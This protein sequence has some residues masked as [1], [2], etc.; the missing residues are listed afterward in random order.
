MKKNFLWL[1][2]PACVISIAC[3]QPAAAAPVTYTYTGTVDHGADDF[4]L[5]GVGGAS[6]SG[7]AFTAVFTRDDALA[8]DGIVVGAFSSSITEF[9]GLGAVTGVITIN[10]VAYNVAPG[11][12]Q[13][14]Q[15]D[16][17][18]YEAFSHIVE[19]GGAHLGLGGGTL[20]TLAPLAAYDYLA[21]G[22][23]HT[24]ASF[25]SA[26]TPGF[27]MF[28]SFDFSAKDMEGRSFASLRAT[29]LVVSPNPGVP[30]GGA[31]PEPATWAM[32]ILGFG[33][34][35]CTLRRRRALAFA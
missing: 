22:D 17:G 29:Q 14:N 20:G 24:L 8:P 19:G 26:N 13:Q 6:L 21:G 18:I 4:G 3:A 28:G 34:V 15:Y 16:D 5:F 27:E 12:S 11:L 23:Y 30:T 25:S 33:G 9:D 10:G 2:L 35:G 7:A 1:A 31:V 32:M